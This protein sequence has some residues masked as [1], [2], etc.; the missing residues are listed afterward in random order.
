MK[1]ESTQ[2]P[3]LLDRPGTRKEIAE[4]VVRWHFH[5]SDDEKLSKMHGHGTLADAI[6]AALNA[7][8]ERASK[9][10]ESLADSCDARTQ[11]ECH[12]KIAAAIRGSKE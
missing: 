12:L 6:E 5:L 7:E 11:Q 9:I 2:F 10:A 8:R 1:S 3:F 4:R